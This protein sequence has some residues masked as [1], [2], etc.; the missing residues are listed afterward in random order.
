MMAAIEYAMDA[1]EPLTEHAFRH[2]ELVVEVDMQT[3]INVVVE[4]IHSKKVPKNTPV[5]HATEAELVR[6][7]PLVL[8][9]KAKK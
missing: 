2:V 1:E 4:D 8:L 5:T 6:M 3:V 7:L 9:A